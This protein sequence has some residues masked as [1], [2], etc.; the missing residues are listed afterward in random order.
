MAEGM[1]LSVVCAE[2]ADINLAEVRLDMLRP[3][4]AASA[5]EELQSIIDSCAMWRVQALPASV[6]EPVV[7]D[8]P[9]LLMSGR[10]DP[11]TPPAFAAAA[12]ATLS[13]ATNIVDPTAA[14]GVA[15]QNPCVNA[16]MAD[17]LN[18]PDT[19]PDTAC[20]AGLEMPN[21]VPPTA[22]TLPLLADVNSLRPRL[23][24]LFGVAA[25]LLLVV[26]SPFLVWPLA[27]L[28]RAFGEKRVERA[29]ED[30]RLRWLGRGLLLAFGALAFVFGVGLLGFVVAAV[31]DLTLTTALSLPSSAAPLLWL[32]LALLLLAVAAVVVLVLM[33]R[34]PGTGSTLGKVYH[35]IVALC[36]IGLLVIIAS[37]GL[38]L[39]PLG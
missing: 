15:F 22:I 21:Y 11:I 17:F 23:L 3:E 16:I 28:V 20:L 31:A 25:V 36:A 9:T 33:W 8:I 12:A 6:D 26:L 7:S 29:P 1:Y 19:P 32:P 13:N 10:F 2:D 38:L 24:A 5:A 34:R 4:I 37:Q 35:A 14:H 39:P 30:S 18:N 27:Y